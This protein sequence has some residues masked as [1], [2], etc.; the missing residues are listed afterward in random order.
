MGT[1]LWAFYEVF[2]ERQNFD[3]HGDE[4]FGWFILNELPAG[5]AGLVVAALFA[6]SMS[7]LDSSINLMRTSVTMD[8]YRRFRCKIC[9]DAQPKSESAEVSLL[10]RHDS[11]ELI[12]AR[13]TTVVL[14]V[15]G[16]LTASWMAWH[17][18]HSISDQFL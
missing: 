11:N 8:F 2:P 6:A 9:E 10:L 12:F 14:D 17:G 15:I 18:T 1:C 13:R 7:S 16:M 5:L 4:I 3:G